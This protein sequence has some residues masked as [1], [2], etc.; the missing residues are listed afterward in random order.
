MYI[1]D[2]PDLQAVLGVF[3]DKVLSKTTYFGV[4]TLKN[5][6]DAWVYQEIICEVRP[7]IVIE[8]GNF[9]GGS[10][11]FLAHILDALG[12]GKVIA[13]DLSHKD[14]PEFIKKNRRIKFIEGDACKNSV[15]VKKLIKRTDKVLVIEDSAHTFENTLNV[16]KTFAP[17]VTKDSY[18]II[19]DSICH[20]G[21][22]VGPNPGPWEAI[23]EFIKDNQEFIIDRSREAFLITYNPK[24]FLRRQT[25]SGKYSKSML[26]SSIQWLAHRFGYH[27]SRWPIEPSSYL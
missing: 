21:I 17:M 27:I 13:L 10:T 2:R 22:A 12:K 19:E 5:P 25:V 7:D 6:L 4:K 8:V 18:L 24:G 1:E 26:T 23:E 3:Q 11:L 15:R 20:H 9:C 16:I 14:V